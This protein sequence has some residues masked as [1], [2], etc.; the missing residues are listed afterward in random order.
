MTQITV[1]D[2]YPVNEL[3]ISKEKINYKN[4]DEILDYL[5]EKIDAHPVATFISIFDHYTHT[6][7]LEVGEINEDIL[8]AKNI[9]FC[10]GKQIPNAAIMAVRP[11]SIAVVEYK[12]NFV[13]T[14][15]DAPNPQAHEAMISW[16]ENI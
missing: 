4:V 6:K 3:T 13:I 16:V 15:M 5:K 10:F 14:F 9:I 8:D 2:K 11:R 12:D 7:G 1:M